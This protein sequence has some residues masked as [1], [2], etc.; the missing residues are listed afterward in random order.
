LDG[1]HTGGEGNEDVKANVKLSLSY[2]DKLNTI[3]VANETLVSENEDGD[4]R[5]VGEDQFYLFLI[6]HSRYD[7]LEYEHAIVVPKST[8]FASNFYNKSQ[9]AGLDN[10]SYIPTGEDYNQQFITRG[11]DSNSAPVEI[12]GVIKL[13]H[14]WPSSGIESLIDDLTTNATG[15]VTGKKYD[16]KAYGWYNDD[17]N[18]DEDYIHSIGLPS[19]VLNMIPNAKK[20]TESA[21]V[22][23]PDDDGGFG[24][25]YLVDGAKY[26][27]GE[28]TE[29]IGNL[30]D[31]LAELGMSLLWGLVDAA[32]EVGQALLNA[33]N[34]LYEWIVSKIKAMFGG[35]IGSVTAGIEGWISGINASMNS[36]FDELAWF[37]NSNFNNATEDEKEEHTE[38]VET[39]GATF[40]LSFLDQQDKAEKLMGMMKWIMEFIEPFSALISPFEALN[41]LSKVFGDGFP[42]VE[43]YFDDM[44]NSG[45]EMLLEVTFIGNSPSLLDMFGI[46][47]LEI[48]NPFPNWGDAVKNFIQHLPEGCSGLL[49][50]IIDFITELDTS[51]YANW[52]VNAIMV[53]LGVY[54]ILTTLGYVSGNPYVTVTFESITLIMTIISFT[55]PN[56][57][58]A[59]LSF[60]TTLFLGFV[61]AVQSADQGNDKLAII[62]LS[63]FFLSPHVLWIGVLANE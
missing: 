41:V 20:E 63:E 55:I 14:L 24:F 1:A 7:G 59:L 34:A 57:E 15:N 2:A 5:Y 58:M 4:W 16:L 18:N 53:G 54:A 49:K 44:L 10:I 3:L 26:W 11:Y 13:E 56:I 48:V 30:A 40:A 35:V 42:D 31:K 6:K 39:V 23:H 21:Y 52:I 50:T 61:G 38:A 51:D 27:I 12:E 45:L 9:T 37:D 62:D 8:F 47:D 33:F 22:D 29:F 19:A 36:F 17:S 28:A 46:P 25:D 60:F 32:K 43:S